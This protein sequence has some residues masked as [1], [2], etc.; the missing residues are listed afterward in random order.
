MNRRW[1]LPVASAG[2]SIVLM[3]SAG[4]QGLCT[5][6]EPKKWEGTLMVGAQGWTGTTIFSQGCSWN[7]ADALNG[8]DAIVWDV[9]GH[10]GV[11]ASI[12]SKQ[13]VG[14]VHNPLLG[15]FYNEDCQR[16]GHWGFT[17]PNTPYAVGIPE[18]AKWFVVYQQ[19][20]GVQTTVTME[21]AGRTCADVETPKP[22]KKKPKKRP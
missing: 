4:A 6:V 18:G 20:G 10:G 3:A 14:A 19:Y 5:P 11:T 13:A 7:G 2:L 15:Y 12:T 21:T 16:G 17:E 8:T 9:S 1:L 22:K